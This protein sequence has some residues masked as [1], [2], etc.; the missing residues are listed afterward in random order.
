[1]QLYV[2]MPP[3]GRVVLQ[4]HLARDP[5]SVKSANRDTDLEDSIEKI[6]KADSIKYQFNFFED[7][8]IST[9]NLTSVLTQKTVVL[10]FITLKFEKF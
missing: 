10:E 5:S 8:K 3:G 6:L 2:Q 4:R 9:R 7:I 1:M